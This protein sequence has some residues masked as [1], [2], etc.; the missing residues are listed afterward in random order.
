M[1][2]IRYGQTIV[3]KAQHRIS[4]VMKYLQCVTTLAR[5]TRAGCPIQSQE[6]EVRLQG[7]ASQVQGFC[8][9]PPGEVGE[10]GRV[11]QE[12]T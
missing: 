3:T 6:E 4:L 9:F 2:N 5:K 1:T 7:G 10:I 12:G 11:A 8:F